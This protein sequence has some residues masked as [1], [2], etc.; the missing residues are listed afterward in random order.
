MVRP[1]R[2]TSDEEI[3]IAGQLLERIE[4]AGK[5]YSQGKYSEALPHCEETLAL[6]EK[7]LG[8]DHFATLTAAAN[9]AAV[10]RELGRYNEA[11]PLFKRK[12]EASERTLGKDVVLTIKAVAI[13]DNILCTF[14]FLLLDCFAPL[15]MTQTIRADSLPPKKNE[16]RKPR[17]EH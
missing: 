1:Y 3:A 7:K 13:Q 9:L 11:E 4:Y 15:A 16:A 14:I 10:Y 8:K 5:L 12:L 17:L 6:A 2:A